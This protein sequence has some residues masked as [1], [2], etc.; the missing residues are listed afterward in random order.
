MITEHAAF[1]ILFSPS[2]G[3]DILNRSVRGC[4]G[5]EK[6]AANAREEG[7]EE[8]EEEEEEEKEL[9]E[10][11]EVE[12]EEE[13]EMEVEEEEEGGEGCLPPRFCPVGVDLIVEFF[14]FFF[15]FGLTWRAGLAA[16]H[17]S[18]LF[19]SLQLLNVHS[20]HFHTNIGE[21]VGQIRKFRNLRQFHNLVI[22][23]HD[24]FVFSIT[25]C[26]RLCLIAGQLLP[27]PT[28]CSSH[29]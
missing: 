28:E 21:D 4:W 8:E 7:E 22:A 5:W 25:L 23:Q 16:S 3:F 11:G 13:V 1:A 18:Q 12:E 9:K 15:F 29:R 14:L 27:N 2:V 20:E 26:P 19:T 17:S 10:G 24:E 6:L